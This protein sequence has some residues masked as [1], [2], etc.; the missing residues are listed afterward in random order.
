MNRDVIISI[1]GWQLTD[2]YAGEVVELVTEGTLSRDGDMYSVKYDESTLT[3]LEG[4]TTV[5][6]IDKERV[7]LSRYGNVDSQLVFEQGKK[8]M[9]FYET[10]FG[11]FT[12]GVSTKKIRSTIEDTGGN[13]EI[14]YMVEVDHA[15]AGQNN[16]KMS[17]RPTN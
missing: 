4:T 7:V 6:A 8:H 2:E 3:G 15:L 1:S 12:V 16:F 5:L 13:I 9:G 17:V 11:A 14:D 10:M